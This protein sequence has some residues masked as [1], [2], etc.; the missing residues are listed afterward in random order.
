MMGITVSWV[1]ETHSAVLLDFRGHWT[2][3]E[4]RTANQQI[5]EMSK[6]VAHVVDIVNDLTY[7][8]GLPSGALTEARAMMNGFERPQGLMIGIQVGGLVQALY[9]IFQNLY[10]RRAGFPETLFFETRQDAFDYIHLQRNAGK[11]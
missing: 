7:S 1:D 5:E 8:S 6:S 4:M 9:P 2:W 10:G 11:E 3:D